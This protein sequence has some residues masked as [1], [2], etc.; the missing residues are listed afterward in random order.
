MKKFNHDAFQSFK[1]KSKIY[2][3]II[4]IPEIGKGYRNISGKG[5]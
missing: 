1:D 4:T 3:L 5:N 2:S